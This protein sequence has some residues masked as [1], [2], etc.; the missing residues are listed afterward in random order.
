MPTSELDIRPAGYCDVDA[1]I[2]TDRA[3]AYY[4]ALYGG[5][6]SSPMEG[7]EFAAPHGDFVL[8]YTDDVPVAMGG[9]RL[10]APIDGFTALRPAEI[11]RMY[12]DPPA[13][14]RGFARSLLT[15]LERTAQHAGV[16][17]LVLETGRPQVEAVALYR[18]AGYAHIPAFG[19]YAGVD[20]AVHLGKL[21]S[22]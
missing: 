7:V 14:G 17:G 5:P 8:G 21:L 20:G 12:V 22:S 19:H 6:D 4:R 13:R 1:R 18:A 3:Q 11:R 10:H 9:W 15:H 2:L 16:D